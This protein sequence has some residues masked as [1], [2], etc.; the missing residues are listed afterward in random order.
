[1]QQRAFCRT[2]YECNGEGSEMMN[3]LKL[4]ELEHLKQR[5]LEEKQA[6]EQLIERNHEFGLADSLRDATGEL[7]TNDNHPADGATEIYER[8]KDIAL[9]ENREH[10]LEQ[11]LLALESMKN[12]TYG[13]CVICG[14][15]IPYERLKAVPS[16]PYCLEH[17]EEN[18]SQRRPAEEDFLHPPF[19]RTSLDD[20][21]Q[22]GFDG[23]DA[24]QIVSSWG[25]SDSP[26]MAEDHQVGDYD[27]VYTEEDEREGYVEPI[28][29]FLASDLY[30]DKVTIVRNEEYYRYIRSKEGDRSLEVLPRDEDEEAGP[31]AVI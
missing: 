10:L 14:Q 27:E 1:L 19:G 21:D 30:G 3:H 23:E 12:G 18:V 22:A 25:N 16:T 20:H 13:R 4:S 8:G 29:S 17:A 24:W 9:L 2:T 5:L 31:D 6:L 28:E 11:V 15:D 7:S 26:A